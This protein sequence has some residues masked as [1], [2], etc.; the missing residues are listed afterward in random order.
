MIAAWNR[1]STYSGLPPTFLGRDLIG[2]CP[3]VL[4]IGT[5]QGLNDWAAMLKPAGLMTE[6]NELL[7]PIIGLSH[8]GNP[9]HLNPEGIDTIT[10]EVKQHENVLILVD[11]FAACLAPLGLKE[12]SPEAAL[13]LQEFAEALDVQTQSCGAWLSRTLNSCIRALIEDGHKHVQLDTQP[14]LNSSG[15]PGKQ[16]KKKART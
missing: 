1:G 7:Y 6:E 13:P 16:R 4:I 12:E 14:K 10:E 11:S 3:K 9:M 5:D 15:F 8:A 2:P